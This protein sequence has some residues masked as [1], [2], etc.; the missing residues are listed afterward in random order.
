MKKNEKCFLDF[1]QF[2]Q[3]NL[4][5]DS[6][7][8]LIYS[9][10]YV[11]CTSFFSMF[12]FQIENINEPSLAYACIFLLRMKLLETSNISMFQRLN[13]LM[14]GNTDDLE[15]EVTFT[16]EAFHLMQVVMKSGLVGS[17]LGYNLRV[18]IG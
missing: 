18:F 1:Y 17:G 16:S 3:K 5:F 8:I 6:K 9:Y 7:V 11:H 14:E 12:Y 13:H 15:N 2:G 10:M 4:Y